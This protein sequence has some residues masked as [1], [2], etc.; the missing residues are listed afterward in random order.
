MTDHNWCERNG[1]TEDMWLS[2]SELS[3][4]NAFVRHGLSER[5]ERLFECACCRRVL[6][7]MSDERSCRAILVAEQYADG[8]A[9]EDEREAAA[10]A[11]A[12]ACTKEL[13]LR[14]PGHEDLLGMPPTLSNAA[15][16]AVID[17]GWWGAAPAFNS[18]SSIIRELVASP[19]QEEAAQCD[20]WRDVVGNPFRPIT[21]RPNWVTQDVVSFASK[22]YQERAASR[23]V[24]LA[25]LLQEAGCDSDE[26]LSHCRGVGPHVRGCW[27]IDMLLGKR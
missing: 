24:E 26:V 9:T 11:A 14:F 18:P 1:M 21:V 22:I 15:Y 13:K 27:V 6:P 2:C 17:M 19:A 8:L 20:L 4:L 16:N 7:Q 10:N 5:K 3:P 12:K 23:M 25:N